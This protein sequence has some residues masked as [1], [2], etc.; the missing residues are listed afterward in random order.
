MVSRRSMQRLTL[1]VA[2]AFGLLTGTAEGQQV[3]VDT[4]Q[5]TAE[6][7][8]LQMDSAMGMMGPM[9]G[10]M[11]EVSMAATLKALS[12]PE[13]AEQL[14][15]FSR[16]YYNAL[17]KKGFTKDQALSIVMSAR[18]PLSSVAR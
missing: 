15:T 7:M 11:A 17:I 13:A 12:K 9:M 4:T 6:Q 1:G 5:P 18:M 3:Q 2:T 14:A 16:N 8:R 10:Q